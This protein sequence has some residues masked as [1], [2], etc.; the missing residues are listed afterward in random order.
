MSIKSTIGEVG[1]ES[2]VTVF[3]QI[4][5]FVIHTVRRVGHCTLKPGRHFVII[6]RQEGLGGVGGGASN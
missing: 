6:A 5:I 2:F 1:A 3:C 4:E